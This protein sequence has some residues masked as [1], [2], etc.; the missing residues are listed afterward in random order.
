MTDAARAPKELMRRSLISAKEQAQETAATQQ[1]GESPAEYAEDHIE[2]AAEDAV[3]R[4]E[5]Y[6]Y[7]A[8][9]G[10]QRKQMKRE[11]SIRRRSEERNRTVPHFFPRKAAL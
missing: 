6:V 9:S 7:S 2:R 4:T 11:N 1:Q 3:W 10:L 5:Q 8:E